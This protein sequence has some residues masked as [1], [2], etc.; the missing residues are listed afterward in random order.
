MVLI[1]GSGAAGATAA[2]ELAFRGFDVTVI[3]RGPCIEDRDAFRCYDE[4]TGTPDLLSTSCVG[5]STL[6]AA[7]N[8]VRVL[9]DRLKD[10]GVDISRTLTP[11]KGTGGV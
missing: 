9:E 3:E 8:A 2:R 5:G 10:Y 6:V 1:V 4:S 7:G 11:L